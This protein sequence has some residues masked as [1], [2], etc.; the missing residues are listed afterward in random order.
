GRDPWNGDFM[1]EAVWAFFE[2]HPKP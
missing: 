2:A 1:W